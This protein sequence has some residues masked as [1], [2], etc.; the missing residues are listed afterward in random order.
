MYH[1]ARIFP[2]QPGEAQHALFTDEGLRLREGRN[3]L[4]VTQLF[5]WVVARS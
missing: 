4:K 5:C 3:L 1:H 2:Y